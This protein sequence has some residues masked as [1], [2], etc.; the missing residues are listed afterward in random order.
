MNPNDFLDRNNTIAVVGVSSNPNK[1]GSRIFQTLKSLG[2]N[3]YPINPKH[4]KIGNT[5][6]Y[7]N[8]ESLPKKPNVVITTVPPKATEKV[9]IECKNIGVDNVWMQPGSESKNAIDFCKKNNIKAV[10][11]AC[12]VADGLGNN[13][14]I[15]DVTFACKKITHEELIKCSFDL[16]KTE[17]N[18][19][20]FLLKN[21]GETTISKIAKGMN[22]ERTTI[23]KA[24][25]SLLKKQLVNRLRKNLPRGGYTYLYKVG[26]RDEIKT[27]MKEIIYDWYNSIRKEIDKL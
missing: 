19:L 14:A 9:V 12:F 15:K 2:F 5:V 21:E 10:S 22:L 13:S 16:N 18:V 17:Y 11:N 6:C 7:P 24:M 3:V 20:I 8:L 27:R 25:K 4:R 23:Q 26:E 1:W